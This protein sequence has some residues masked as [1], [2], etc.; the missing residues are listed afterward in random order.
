VNTVYSQITTEVILP[1]HGDNVP[2]TSMDD[3][4]T[5]AAYL[6]AVEGEEHGATACLGP[7]GRNT[8]TEDHEYEEG[9]CYR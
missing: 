6:T 7:A 1:G 3:T 8:E 4:E 2:N 9:L 5:T